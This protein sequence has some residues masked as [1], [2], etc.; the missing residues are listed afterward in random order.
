MPSLS[1][2]QAAAGLLLCV[3][4]ASA[5]EPRT[6]S[7][8]NSPDYVAEDTVENFTH[9]TGIHV[10]YD[11]YDAYETFD[12]KLLAGGSGYDVVFS[13]AQPFAQQHVARGVYR[14]VDRAKLPRFKNLDPA[15]LKALEKVDPG[16]R[17]L[18]PY[19]WGTTGIGYNA[20]KV[21]EVLGDAA[22]VDSLR[23]L[24]DPEVV[25]RL[26][27]CGVTVLDD[28]G[29]GLGAA[30][31][32]LGKDPNTTNEK[33]IEAA[34]EVVAQA[35]PHV[36]YFHSSRYIDDLAD[37][38]VCVSLGHSGDVLRARDRAEEADNGVEVSFSIPKEGALLWVDVMAIPKDAPRPDNAHAFIDFL[39]RPDI[40]ADVSN[41][42]SYANANQAAT[43]LVDEEIRE[44]PGI[45]PPR[46]LRARLVTT[47]SPP[48]ETQRL[49]TRAW[50]RATTGR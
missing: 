27:R 7:V 12:R 1:R 29:Q 40:I 36:R 25:Y 17:H 43:K 2:A 46:E 16:N 4:L 23:M 13:P 15:I 38:S 30:L 8:Y 3:S 50:T 45:Y 9:A 35:R 37:G 42:I 28:E 31:L 20:A 49:R 34:A 10:T 33:D 39:L 11:V 5:A 22:P 19:M 48:A 32:Y 44:D 6:L 14:P 41:F 24:F 18:V 47:E 21:R 26:A